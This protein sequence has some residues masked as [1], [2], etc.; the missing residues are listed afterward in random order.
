M[1]SIS[2]HEEKLTVNRE[3]SRLSLQLQPASE[4]ERWSYQHLKRA[5][6]ACCRRGGQQ[7]RSQQ[8]LLLLP[9][10]EITP[11][12]KGS[13][14]STSVSGGIGTGMAN[15]ANLP[16]YPH[17]PPPY[18]CLQLPG[19]WRRERR[20]RPHSGGTERLR[21]VDAGSAEGPDGVDELG[22]RRRVFCV[23]V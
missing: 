12:K 3:P 19:G 11:S 15:A 10:V 2:L 7:I 5:G 1:F 22:K 4:L 8:E 18:Y 6:L 17:I 23:S 14:P 21:A 9:S 13:A 16:L 20:R